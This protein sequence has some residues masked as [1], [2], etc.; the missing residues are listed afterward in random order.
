MRDLVYTF[1]HEA[2]HVWLCFA[3]VD[4][5]RDYPR[6]LSCF[7][8]THVRIDNARFWGRCP[9]QTHAGWPLLLLLRSAIGL[10][11]GLVQPLGARV[12]AGSGRS[13]FRRLG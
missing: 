9:M 11:G 7:P 13:I 4:A 6:V 5:K 8:T 12:D 2:S 10:E 1:V 3:C